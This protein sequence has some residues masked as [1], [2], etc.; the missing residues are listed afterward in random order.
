MQTSSEFLTDIEKFLEKNSIAPSTF[1]RLLMGDP[2]FVFQL[3]EGR[4][5]SLETAEKINRIIQ[6]PQAS[7]IFGRRSKK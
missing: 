6:H 3:R 7:G 5:P 4:S 1:G 2:T